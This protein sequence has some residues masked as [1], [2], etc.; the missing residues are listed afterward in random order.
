M[1][2]EFKSGDHACRISVSTPPRSRPI[3]APGSRYEAK[4]KG[5][6]LSLINRA[7]Q[8][9]DATVECQKTYRKT[10][11]DIY[12]GSIAGYRPLES[13]LRKVLP[14]KIVGDSIVAYPLGSEEARAI[15]NSSETKVFDEPA[16]SS[17][18]ERDS[19]RQAENPSQ[20]YSSSAK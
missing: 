12:P 2:T 6:R 11:F 8:K 9:V 7:T 17:F 18:T 14:I 3:I 1:E 4:W 5:S 10:S 19:R 20:I 15:S 16:R 13:E